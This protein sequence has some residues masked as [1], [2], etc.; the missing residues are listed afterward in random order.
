M[1]TENKVWDP[2]GG[3][4][5]ERVSARVTDDL[6][7][8]LVAA[9]V[10]VLDD[11][12]DDESNSVSRTE[13]DSHANMPVVGRNSFLIS[14][15][16]R[17]ADVSAFSPD[18]ASMKIPIVDAAIRYDCPY[19]GKTYI[20]VIRNALHVPSMT[21]NLIPPSMMREAGVVVKDT[22]KIQLDDPTVE[23]HSIYFHETNFRIPLQ[24]WGIFS[25][26]PTIRP[27]SQDV[28]ESDEVYLLTTSRWDPHQ[29]AY[30]TNEDSML[31]WEG[32]II[33]K[34]NRRQTILLAEIEEDT[35]MT[36]SVQIGSIEMEAVESIEKGFTFNDDMP[37]R[38]S[39]MRLE[40]QTKCQVSLRASRRCSMTKSCT[41]RSSRGPSWES[42]KRR[43]DRQISPQ[44]NTSWKM[45]RLWRLSQTL[46]TNPQLTVKA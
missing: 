24:L 40:K 41:T 20:L 8:L 30:S 35:A 5:P 44:A 13:L 23:D 12:E 2:G 28:M 10:S 45:R 36:A 3:Q 39:N 6:H 43:S 19:D 31:D 7:S 22:P 4:A 11:A 16:G 37:Y 38:A 18:I 34:S 27:T 9:Q 1:Q 26:F 29:K 17:I 14:D 21:N 32:N 33:D 25:Y 42:S 15:T 46:T